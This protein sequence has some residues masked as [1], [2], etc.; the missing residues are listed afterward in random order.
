MFLKSL[1]LRISGGISQLDNKEIPKTALKRV[2]TLETAGLKIKQMIV[3]HEAPPLLTA[4]EPEK[5]PFEMPDLKPTI[6]FVVNAVAVVAFGFFYLLGY[7]LITAVTLDP[8]LIVVLEDGSWI[9]V[10]RWY[11]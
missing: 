4:P 1:Y 5:K 8:A 9:E 7:A 11:E 2:V 3:A 6:D 10:M